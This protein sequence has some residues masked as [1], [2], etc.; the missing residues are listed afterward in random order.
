MENKEMISV[1]I[2]VYNAEKTIKETVDSIKNQSWENWE[3]ILVNDGSKDNSLE[4]CKAL[5]GPKI[6]LLNKENGGVVSA[7]K[8]GIKAAAG[9]LIAFCDADDSYK[10]DFLERASK[11][12]TENNC[13]FVSFGAT[14]IKKGQSSLEK[15][16]LEEGYYDQERIKKELLPHCLFNDFIP[17]SYY[18]IHVYRWNKV[19]KKELIDRFI[20]QLDEKCFQ[21]EDNIFTT[22]AILNAQSFYVDNSSVYN[23]VIQEQSITTACS[24]DLIDRYSY[25]LSILKKITE[26]YLN[27][28]NPKQ[29][30]LL[31]WENYRI[32]FRRIAKGSD[33]KLA[34]I[35]VAKIRASGYIDSV[36]LSEIKLLKNYLFY[37]FYHTRLDFLLYLSFKLL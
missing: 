12:I 31:A 22:L 11:I 20:E 16:A 32:V 1:I 34:K 21:V 5:E 28:Y 18:K 36:K 17:G 19:Y 10:P 9:S 6:R 24:E 25:S 35:A 29:F 33:F 26:K 14:L 27:A 23:Y 7:Y 37:F 3:I 2:P 8:A 13:D 4:A 30:N 15:N